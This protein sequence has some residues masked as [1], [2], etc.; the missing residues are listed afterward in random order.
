MLLKN[1]ESSWAR[2]N[3]ALRKK[4]FG[5]A[6]ALY[7]EALNTA[8]DVLKEYIHFNLALARKKQVFD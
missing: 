2:A 8:D 7:E 5:T 6:V 3:A 1:N 4:D